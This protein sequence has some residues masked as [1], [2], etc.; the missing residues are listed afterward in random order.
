MEICSDAADSQTAKLN[1]FVLVAHRI[2]KAGRGARPSL[3]KFKLRSRKG[4]GTRASSP[5]GRNNTLAANGLMVSASPELSEAPSA[6]IS[7]QPGET[8]NTDGRNRELGT[9]DF[10]LSLGSN[11]TPANKRGSESFP[12]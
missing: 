3:N 6:P 9:G 5:T 7:P 4:D 10:D 12:A 2:R 8:I 11:E 1:E